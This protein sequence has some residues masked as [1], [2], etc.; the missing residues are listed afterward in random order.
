MEKVTVFKVIHQTINNCTGEKTSFVYNMFARKEEA[1][2]WMDNMFRK[3]NNK[4][5]RGEVYE[6][7]DEEWIISS[8]E[9]K[10]IFTILETKE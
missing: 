10:E 3:L 1:I 2:V 6:V 7:H 5:K 8:K 4:N 9:T